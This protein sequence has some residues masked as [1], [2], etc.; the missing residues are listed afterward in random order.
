MHDI[1]VAVLSGAKSSVTRQIKSLGAAVALALAFANPVAAADLGDSCCADL[2]ERIAELEATT[3]RKGNRKVSLSVT[4]YVTKQIMFWDDGVERNAYI[5]DVGPTQATN[6]RF[7]GEATI[8]PGWKAGYMMRIQ[9]LTDNPMGSSQFV[10][11]TNMGLN[12]QMAHWYLASKELGKLSVGRNALAAK[13]A[14]MFTDL[15]GTQ[16][17]ANYVLFDGGG[18]FL[19]QDGNLTGLKWGDF[20]YCYAQQRPWGGDC[21]GIVMNGV[22]YDSPVFAGFS[23]SASWGEDDDREIAARYAGEA[24]GFKLAFGVGYSVNTD[25]QT[26]P[27]PISLSKDSAVF[28]AGGYAQH[29]ATGLFLHAAYG[30]EDNNDKKTFAGFTEPNSHQ[31]YVKGGVRRQWLPVGHT[32]IYGEYGAYIDQLSPAA[33]AAG[34]TS[35][36]FERFGVGA[37]QEIDAASMS[38][39]VKYREHHADVSGIGL[40]TLDDFRYV[41]TGALINF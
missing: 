8:A 6:F 32:V 26:Q 14:A 12:V 33:L 37:V 15:S 17:I 5:T 36:E 38:L 9:D 3:A 1:G 21:D 19:R 20:G 18:F 29:L 4:G 31:W 41:S 22:R 25:E 39:W 40:G 24:A 10:D 27:P 16:V 11:S 34:A 23:V 30:E 35:S 28:Q 2:E 7:T 13:S